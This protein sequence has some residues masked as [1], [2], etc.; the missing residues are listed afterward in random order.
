MSN[1]S[2]TSL[3]N[4]ESCLSVAT[5][6]RPSTS[7]T[8]ANHPAAVVQRSSRTAMHAKPVFMKTGIVETVTGCDGHGRLQDA[9]AK[10]AMVE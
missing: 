8:S 10:T 1:L 9:W 7:S 4:L 3:Q 5:Y 2:E 6:L